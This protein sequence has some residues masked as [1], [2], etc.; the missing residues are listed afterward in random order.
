VIE[1][2][3]SKSAQRSDETLRQL[4]RP[5]AIA[6]V[7]AE[8]V[9]ERV[10][11]KGRV[12][13]TRPRYKNR[14]GY[15]TSTAYDKRAG[16]RRGDDTNESSAAWHREA[17]APVGRYN[18]TGGMWSGMF[19]RNRGR[20]AAMVDFRGSTL[21]RQQ[22]ANKRLDDQ[23]KRIRLR[24]KDRIKK[25][26]GATAKQR[27]R[28]RRD[29]RIATLRERARAKPKRVGNRLKAGSVW[30]A[31]RVNVV[32]PTRSEEDALRSAYAESAAR[33]L[34]CTFGAENGRISPTGDQDLRRKLLHTLRSIR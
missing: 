22:A 19:V 29:E 17:R 9:R 33:V 26:K 2:R 32:Q 15:K 14:G 4:E 21:G 16:V 13:Y 30:L 7:L 6:Q 23:I 20:R 24:A 5:V 31:H 11:R 1:V 10:R 28:Q 27:A 34:W 25:A 18:T 12:A 8:H 3:I